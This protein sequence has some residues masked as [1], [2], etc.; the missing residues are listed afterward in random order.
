MSRHSRLT[1]VDVTFLH[2]TERAILV[3]SEIDVEVWLRKS[4]CEMAEDD[5]LRGD[6]V[7]I[8]AS[9]SFLTA[10]GLI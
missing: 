3:R 7:T 10:K 4:L 2:Q 9:E 6:T 8:T 1:D 5:P